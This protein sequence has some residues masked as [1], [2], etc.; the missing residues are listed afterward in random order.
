MQIEVTS[1]LIEL[2]FN[3]T[4]FNSTIGLKFNI[5]QFEFNWEKNGIQIGG[6]DIEKLRVNMMLKKEFFFK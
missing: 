4:K 6:K 2:D 3:S 5:I 1:D